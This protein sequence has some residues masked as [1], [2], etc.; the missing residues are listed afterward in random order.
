M[1]GISGGCFGCWNYAFGHATK[2]TATVPISGGE[3]KSLAC[4]IKGLGIWAI[5]NQTDGTVPISNS[6]SMIDAINAC[7]DPKITP[8]FSIFPGIGHDCWRRVYDQNHPDRLIPGKN[9]IAKVDI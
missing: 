6:Q 3:N 1:I 8:K 4:N 9:G 2:P 5:H 7:A